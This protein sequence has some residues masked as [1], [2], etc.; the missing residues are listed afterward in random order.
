VLAL[1]ETRAAGIMTPRERVTALA[2]DATLEQALRVARRARHARFPVLEN[3]RVLGFVH[4]KDLAPL[5]HRPDPEW[6]ASEHCR[7]ALAVAPEA[8]VAHVLEAFRRKRS[9]LA[10]V[11]DRDGHWR[12]IITLG[13]I[14]RHLLG[15]RGRGVP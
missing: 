12:G 14:Y 3:D 9:H 13:D 7:E 10:V 6:R 8:S 11:C 5:R 15:P 2:A 1:S 4:V